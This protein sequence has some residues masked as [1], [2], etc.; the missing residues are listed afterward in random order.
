[1]AEPARKLDDEA[2]EPQVSKRTER[3]LGNVA[4]LN[5]YRKK[6]KKKRARPS[7]KKEKPAT[8]KTTRAG[9]T[10]GTVIDL[11][12]ARARRQAH[13]LETEEKT[14]TTPSGKPGPVPIRTPLAMASAL[15]A[16]QT[17]ERMVDAPSEESLPET[18]GG[19]VFLELDPQSY[20]L[21]AQTNEQ[22]ERRRQAAMMETAAR[23]A[24]SA[25]VAKQEE[26]SRPSEERPREIPVPGRVEGPAAGRTP[27]RMVGELQRGKA[28]ERSRIMEKTES[29]K[30]LQQSIL[31]QRRA[32]VK[33]NKNIR[34]IA[35]LV[36]AASAEAFI[37]LI[38]LVIQLNLEVINKWIF[39]IE[40]PG[41]LLVD[42]NPTL[43]ATDAVTGLVDIL[44]VFA[45]FLVFL[46]TSFFI[47]LGIIVWSGL[48]DPLGS[49]LEIFGGI[50]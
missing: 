46:Q 24:P 40:I 43:D 27:I 9:Q 8:E 6:Q 42:R 25:T 29:A 26:T 23:F 44:L 37:P 35:K 5:A 3:A 1:M 32:A 21:Q 39:K 13:L 15:G 22:K 11:N 36:Q 50:F 2:Q 14:K 48:V 12:E 7:D 31:Q 45:F 20:A 19:R 18:S 49:L 33:A 34:R 28:A 30:N 4:D 16:A 41:L 17:R 10:A 38:T 47:I